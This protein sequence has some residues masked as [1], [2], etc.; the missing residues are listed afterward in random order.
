MNY[1]F[2]LSFIAVILSSC[3]TYRYYQPTTNPALFKDKG[4]VHVS[5]D[6]GSSG[7]AAK[8][9]FSPTKEL[10]VI[11]QYNTHFTTYR[12][13]EGELAAGYHSSKESSANFIGGGIGFGTNLKYTD[14]TH[15][16]K[17]YEG[18]FIKPFV[19]W[20]TGITGGTIIGG[21]KG[22]L[23][24]TLKETY[25]IY[26]GRHLDGTNDEISSNYFITEPVV[27]VAL[28]SKS[29]KFDIIYGF[30]ITMRWFGSLKGKAYAR[31]FPVNIGVGI[32]FIFNRK[33]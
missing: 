22:D 11:G 10:G 8:F 5:G 29:F 19:Q 27:T 26:N 6:V 28:G 2:V 1:L 12:V 23:I 15:S 30:P 20:N 14:S 32:R 3:G 13:W 21:L 24:F 33:K 17:R 7:A 4:E 31:T 9:A 18:N 16:S 25:M